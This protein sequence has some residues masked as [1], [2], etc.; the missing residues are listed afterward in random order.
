[1]KDTGAVVLENTGASLFRRLVD[2]GFEW[3]FWGSCRLFS[4]EDYTVIVDNEAGLVCA[5]KNFSRVKV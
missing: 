4:L 1:M 5:C 3:N 2:C